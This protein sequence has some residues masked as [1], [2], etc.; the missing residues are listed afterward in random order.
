MR[1]EVTLFVRQANVE[2]V[3]SLVQ[4]YRRFKDL[5]DEWID[6]ASQLCELKLR[7]D[8]YEVPNGSTQAIV[9]SSPG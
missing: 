2:M 7:P 3:K 9:T 8:L 1:S 5:I 4:N 6:L